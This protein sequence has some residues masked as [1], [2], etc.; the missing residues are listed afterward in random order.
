M[1]TGIGSYE[2][3]VESQPRQPHDGETLAPSK[4]SKDQGPSATYSTTSLTSDQPPKHPVFD[5]RTHPS[6]LKTSDTEGLLRTRGTQKLSRK[7]VRFLGYIHSAIEW[8]FT[9]PVLQD[10]RITESAT[11]FRDGDDLHLF[12]IENNVRR[13]RAAW[14]AVSES[15]TTRNWE[16]DEDTNA[17]AEPSHQLH[18]HVTKWGV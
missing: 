5:K 18:P 10:D 17:K 9:P 1:Y 4:Q 8:R 6:P 11:D 12:R 3:S 2:N 14:R 13:D 16:T 7:N 15:R